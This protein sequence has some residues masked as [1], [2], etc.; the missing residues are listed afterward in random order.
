MWGNKKGY[1]ANWIPSVRFYMNN[2]A[3]SEYEIIK[4]LME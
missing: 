2:E 1:G 4:S 3:K